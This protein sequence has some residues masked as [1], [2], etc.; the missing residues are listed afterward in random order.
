M[1]HSLY[2][3][4]VHNRTAEAVA[5]LRGCAAVVYYMT[6]GRRGGRGLVV[7]S[8]EASGRRWLLRVRHET[9]SAVISDFF[10]LIYLYKLT[11]SSF[12]TSHI[13]TTNS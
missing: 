6:D 11:S 10:F 2:P 4:C 9:T 5:V 3:K 7:Y 1:K 8:A 13:H 12:L